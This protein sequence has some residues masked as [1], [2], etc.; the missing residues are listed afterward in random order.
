MS[1]ELG[2]LI[3]MSFEASELPLLETIHIDCCFSFPRAFDRSVHQPDEKQQKL[4]LINI[5][6]CLRTAKSVHL[7]PS[8]VKLLSISHGMLVQEHCSFGNLKVLNLIPP[9]NKPMAELHSSVTAY[10]LKDSP[11]AVVKAEPRW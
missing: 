6:R 9:P 10:L 1:L 3:P 7:T 4:N 8:T 2:G 11:Q 5:L